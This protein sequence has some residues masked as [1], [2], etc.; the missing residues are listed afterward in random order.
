MQ[1]CDTAKFMGTWFVIGVKPTILEKIN[2]NA[3][4]VYSLADE[5]DSHDINIDFK[6]NKSDPITSS[7]KSYPQKG[8]VDSDDKTNSGKW[9]VSPMWPIKL[10]FL[11]LEVDDNYEY[12]VIGYPSR[13]YAWIM[14]R[15]PVMDQDTYDMLVKRLEEKHQ[16][17][18]NGFRKV[19]QEW[20]KE[21]RSKRGLDDIIPDDMLTTKK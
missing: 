1:S 15:K 9:K 11:I 17:D 18:L 4:E 8:W 5:T 2:S 13:A 10:P 14:A 19:V 3:V 6:T 16:Y 21:E 12:T 7:L 20:T